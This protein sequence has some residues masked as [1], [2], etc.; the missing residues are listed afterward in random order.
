MENTNI[1]QNLRIDKVVL[2]IGVGESG[3]RLGKAEQLIEKISNK[4]PVRTVSRHKIP[5][6]GL[7]LGEPIGAKVTIRG[8]DAEDVLKR[9]L[10]AKDN[11]LRESNFDRTGNLSF[12]IQEYLDLPGIKYD[13][14]IGIF[15]FNICATIERPGYRIK[16]RRIRPSKIPVHARVTR[17]ESVEFIKKKFGI[18]IET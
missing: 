1:M 2:N 3:E 4:K 10:A 8:K 11:R 13:P 14:D 12:G 16:R 9:C 6:W 15:G 5:A 7:K 17:D 18:E